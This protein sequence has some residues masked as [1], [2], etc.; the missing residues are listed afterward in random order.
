M[1][2]INFH[3]P[4][5]PLNQLPVRRLVGAPIYRN[6]YQIDDFSRNGMN[7]NTIRTGYRATAIV[8]AGPTTFT[9]GTND[10]RVNGLIAAGKDVLG[11]INGN[12]PPVWMR[13]TGSTIRPDKDKYAQYALD[14][15]THYNTG[16]YA[17]PNNIKYFEIC[18]EADGMWS[19]DF[20]GDM[21]L[22]ADA[23]FEVLKAVWDKTAEFRASHPD[24]KIIGGVIAG[25]PVSLRGSTNNYFDQLWTV[26]EAWRYMDILSFHFY[27][28]Q[29]PPQTYYAP[30]LGDPG[31]GRLWDQV[32]M[33]SLAKIADHPI[34]V[35]D[36][37]T[38]YD[39]DALASPSGVKMTQTE[40]AKWLVRS[41][42]IV[43][44]SGFVDRFLQFSNLDMADGDY[45]F[46]ASLESPARELYKAYGT[47]AKVL[48]STITSIAMENY[49]HIT[50]PT[51]DF[52][53]FKYKKAHGYYGWSVWWV[54]NGTNDTS[55][56]VM[57]GNGTIPADAAIYTRTMSGTS[58]VAIANSRTG[59]VEVSVTDEPLYVEVRPGG[60]QLSPK[61]VSSAI[62]KAAAAVDVPY[63]GSI[64]GAGVDPD[65]ST[66]TFAK[67]SGPAW[68]SVAP[69][70]SIT[71]TPQAANL[72][73]NTF[74]VRVI[75]SVG[76]SSDA[77]LQIQVQPTIAPLPSTTY[78]FT[79]VGAEDGYMR[80]FCEFLVFNII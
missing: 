2:K 10:N 48:D 41:A 30:E 63:N 25:A 29:G 5:R 57:L 49:Y 58:W 18:N 76:G 67:V 47:M 74:F 32:L 66:L 52:C 59:T 24:I 17:S 69:D 20:G 14:V 40:H 51:I 65:H 73:L 7:L 11:V 8:N 54:P 3:R 33:P 38:G 21:R 6:P 36:T 55:G 60:T 26:R 45:G 80:D 4:R 39:V 50:A 19:S 61:W 78:T 70:G 68:L 15:I 64:A 77:M 28:R 53:S 43:R 9:W 79:S 75:S 56:T 42:I 62:A 35:W 13:A 23:Y 34:P 46:R 31:K 72:G 71:G 27:V 12:S 44:G 22:T 37:E 16:I 1:P